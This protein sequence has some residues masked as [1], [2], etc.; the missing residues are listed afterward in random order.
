LF[1]NKLSIG[2]VVTPKDS[3]AVRVFNNTRYYL[4]SYKI[5]IE[6]RS[7]TFSDIGKHQYSV[8]KQLPYLPTVYRKNVTFVRKRLLQYDEWIQ[9]LSVP[10]DFIGENNLTSGSVTIKVKA[11][12]VDS[13][14]TIETE[15]VKQ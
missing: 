7:Y 1:A 5:D 15:L 11:K 13:K 12:K 3:V 8:Y 14:W 10:V 9:I 2:Q 4:K 6:N